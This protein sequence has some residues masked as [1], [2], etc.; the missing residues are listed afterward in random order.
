[1]NFSAMGSRGQNALNTHM[2]E[3]LLA[4]T[5]QFIRF[6]GV[7][8]AAKKLGIDRGTINR[9]ECGESVRKHTVERIELALNMP[10]KAKIKKKR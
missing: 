9:I 10:L 5:L 2:P 7:C 4:E 3:H 8:L 6:W 1:M